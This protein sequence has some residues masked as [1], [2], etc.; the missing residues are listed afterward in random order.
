[1]SENESLNPTHFEVPVEQPAPPAAIAPVWHTVVLIA[2]II[3]LSIIG[4]AQVANM[5]GV[6][7]RMLT[8]GETAG[9]E[10]LMLGWVAFGLRLRRV[11]FRSLFG[12]VTSGLRGLGLDLGIAFLFW[13]GSLMIL[14]TLGIL[15]TGVAMAIEHRHVPDRTGRSIEPTEEQKQTV[16]MLEE[17]APANG[18]EVACWIL[19]CMIAGLIEEAVFRGYLQHQFTAWAHGGVAAGVIFSALLFGAAHGYQ[20]V[21]NMVLLAVFGVLF[22]LL[23]IFRRS[24]R[25]GIFAHGWHDMIAGLTLAAL[26]SRHL[27]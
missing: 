20:G 12:H 26:H 8:Y 9:M 14:G 7:S 6:P 21:R 22:S 5:H 4:K 17:L 23:A 15:W 27:I 2:G 10:I 18:K 3:A 11:P 25:A 16:R 13:I 24:L 1:M 19:L